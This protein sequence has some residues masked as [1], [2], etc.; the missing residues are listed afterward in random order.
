MQELQ[1]FHFPSPVV[2]GKEQ[3]ITEFLVWDR[4]S[5]LLCPWDGLFFA[6]TNALSQAVIRLP[7]VQELVQVHGS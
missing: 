5:Q 3:R 4:T 7:P 1:E 2:L 6:A